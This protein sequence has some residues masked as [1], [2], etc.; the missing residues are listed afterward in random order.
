[1]L[2]VFCVF[3]R[4]TDSWLRVSV[5]DC[6]AANCK[7]ISWLKARGTWNQNKSIGDA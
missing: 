7:E 3:S 1:M 5:N 2:G 6:A 4:E